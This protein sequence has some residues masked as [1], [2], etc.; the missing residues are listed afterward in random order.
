[1]PNHH[2]MKELGMTENMFLLIWRHFHVGS[3]DEEADLV[4]TDDADNKEELLKICL[5]RVQCEQ[6]EQANDCS[7]ES[8]EE[9]GKDLQ[10]ERTV[11]YQKLKYLIDHVRDV[12]LDIIF[13]LGTWVAI[14]EMMIRFMVRSLVTHCIKNE[15]IEESL[16]FFVLAITIGFIITFTPDGHTAEKNNQQDYKTHRLG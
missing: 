11:W 8:E 7:S 13:I 15:P 4:I 10:N 3:E 9:E 5:V 12:D 14:D 1:M 2:I 6:E 16:K